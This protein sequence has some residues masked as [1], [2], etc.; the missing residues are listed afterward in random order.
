MVL[1][2][3]K[4]FSKEKVVPKY[5]EKAEVANY[6]EF[7]ARE[8]RSEGH[9]HAPDH[10]LETL[11]ARWFDICGVTRSISERGN[12]IVELSAGVQPLS[13]YEDDGLF[14]CYPGELVIDKLVRLCIIARAGPALSDA[15]NKNLSEGIV[16]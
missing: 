13:F 3:A 5:K 16:K 8:G 9:Q 10:V 2:S 14:F 6:I 1:S 7:I 15:E 11:L 12:V 4:R